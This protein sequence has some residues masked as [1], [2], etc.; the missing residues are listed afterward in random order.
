MLFAATVDPSDTRNADAQ[1]CGRCVCL[2][3]G[4]VNLE[5]FCISP[6]S[7]RKPVP[8]SPINMVIIIGNAKSS[9]LISRSSIIL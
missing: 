8:K 3:R 2:K 4:S 1:D 6:I 5:N 9:T 7:I